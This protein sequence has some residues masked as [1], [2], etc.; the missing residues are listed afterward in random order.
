LTVH[1]RRP[2]D[3]ATVWS[4]L[5]HNERTILRHFEYLAIGGLQL[6]GRVLDVGGGRRSAYYDL[7]LADGPIDSLNIDTRM[8]PTFVAD[9]GYGL[10]VNSAS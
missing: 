4:F 8:K 2:L 5:R 1:T 7:I 3:T 10:P 9:F 6:N